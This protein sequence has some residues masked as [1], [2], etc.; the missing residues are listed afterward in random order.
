MFP[1]QRVRR[2]RQRGVLAELELAPVFLAVPT[3]QRVGQEDDVL[4]ALPQRRQL[5]RHDR[6]PEV[7]VLPEAAA[8]DLGLEVLVG[9]RD[10]PDVDLDPVP[11]ADPL[12]L[13]LLE[14]PEELDLEREAHLADL[15]EEERAAV[16]DL[17]LPLPLDVG[18]R[19]GALLVPEQLRLQQRLGDRPAVDRH[20]RAVA[21]AALRVERAGEQFLAGSA[22]ALDEDRGVGPGDARHDVEDLA[23]LGRGA[24]RSPRSGPPPRRRSPAW[25]ASVSTPW[26]NRARRRTTL[27]ASMSTGFAW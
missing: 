27:S 21:P 5:D 1:G 7:E 17:E 26:R 9:R 23:H 10:D 2:E 19:V 13:P 6:Q 3:E 25:A 22:L 15:V 20:E 18:A 14:E 11:A 8:R 24:R 16:G 12:D 4:P